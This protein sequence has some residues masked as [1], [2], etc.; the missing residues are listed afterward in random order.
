M[1]MIC[2]SCRCAFEQ[3]VYCPQCR[4][5]LQ[6]QSDSQRNRAL[7]GL[8][9]WH[10]SPWGRVALGLGLSQGLFYGLRQL[11]T[12]GFL[13]I[14]GS[15]A[16]T[17]NQALSNLLLLQGLQLV[18]L[19]LGGILVGAGRRQ[20]LIYGMVLGTW[21]GVL[22]ILLYPTGGKTFLALSLYGQPLLQAVVGG[23]GGWLG[24]RIWKPFEEA[25]APIRAP[26]KEPYRPK[27][28][29]KNWFAGK[30]AW[31]RVITGCAVAI[32]GTVW[33]DVI[34]DLIQRA[35]RGEL[36]LRTQV[37]AQLLTW[38]IIALAILGGAALAGA[39]TKN[40]LKQGMMVGMITAAVLLGLRLAEPVVQW[41]TLAVLVGGSLLLG[42]LGGGFGGQLLPPVIKQ[43]KRRGIFDP[44]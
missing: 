43:S 2:P 31:G 14:G 9:A 39:T 27:I 4:T 29:P 28:K 44:A 41:E 19:L 5:Q 18:A 37:H 22:C 34:F 38:E 7:K 13:A 15:D 11:V 8:S 42:L 12:A 25:S 26:E 35:G 40:G 33:A 1:P 20:S 10:Q 24:S 32:G 3:R 6:Y 30:I 16:Q 36:D 17:A 21:N 23:F